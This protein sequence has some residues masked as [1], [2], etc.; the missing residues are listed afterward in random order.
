MK[1]DSQRLSEIKRVYEDGAAT[2]LARTSEDVIAKNWWDVVE[3]RDKFLSYISQESTILDV[4]CGTGRDAKYFIQHGHRVV[5]IDICE[6]FILDLQN[7]TPGNYVIGDIVDPSSPVYQAKYDA[8]WCNAAIVHLTREESVQVMR[9]CF[10]SLREWWVLFVAT[11]YDQNKTHMEEKE[12]KS[13]PGSTKTY[14]YYTEI[15]LTN[16]LEQTWFQ[17]L[18]KSFGQWAYWWDQFIRMYCK[19]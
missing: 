5:G 4:G 12:S 11:K 8:I 14:A 6:A 19:K 2:F 13:I 7:T 17:I 1:T 3:M 16:D 18:E 15:D 9:N 10:D